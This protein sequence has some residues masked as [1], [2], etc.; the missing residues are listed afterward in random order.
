MTGGP[1]PLALFDLDR[2]L[3]DGRTIHHL[4]ETFGVFEPAEQA[5]QA[6]RDGRASWRETKQRVAGL[7]EGVP[8]ARLEATCRQ[9]AFDPHATR[10][11]GELKDAGYRVG[12]LTASYE[13]AAERARRDL[14]LDV[15]YGTQLLA[16][17]GIVTGRL[18]GPR[19]TGECGRWI[20]KSDALEQV[21]ERLGA[22]ATLA[23]GDGPN[24][25]C[26]LAAA[27]LGIAVDPD[28][29]EA[30]D[31]ADLVAELGEVP[32]LAREHLDPSRPSP[33]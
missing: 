28:R 10:V 16:E 12:L 26:M 21:C 5:W 18:G 7:F 3:L 23:V 11:V 29:R 17:D 20:C 33:A 14:D 27:D 2:T 8:V 32:R 4:A 6:Y 19:F 9:L 25:A 30:V 22:S 24:D 31:A 15:A 1:A 13:F